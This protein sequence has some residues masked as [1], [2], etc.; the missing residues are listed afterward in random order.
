VKEK[1]SLA[2]GLTTIAA[3]SILL[4]ATTLN[5][6]NLGVGRTDAN[7]PPLASEAEVTALR[8][9]VEDLRKRVQAL[10]HPE[11]RPQHVA[12]DQW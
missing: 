4:M 12:S 7:T 6:S 8:L 5:M 3:L 1:L 10:E 11:A 9:D 2:V